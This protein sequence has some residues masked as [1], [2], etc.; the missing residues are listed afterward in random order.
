MARCCSGSPICGA[1]KL[2]TALTSIT[3]VLITFA[4]LC[5]TSSAVY[6]D[7]VTLPTGVNSNHSGIMLRQ[8]G[9]RVMP[10]S[11]CDNL[12]AV[13]GRGPLRARA[14]GTSTRPIRDQID[15]VAPARVP[16]PALRPGPEPGA[17]RAWGRPACQGGHG[18]AVLGLSQGESALSPIADV[19]GKDDFARLEHGEHNII[20]LSTALAEQLGVSK[21]QMVLVGGL[22]CKWP[23]SL[24]LASLTAASIFSA[25]SR[26]RLCATPP[27]RWMPAAQAGRHEG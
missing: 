23:A 6:L 22:R 10:E 4:V 20:Y 24:T 26:F 9:W 17:A 7:T 14:G 3:I 1:G 18:G 13:V 19:I 16:A 12:L 21:G 25:A 5:F 15:L 8:R 27:V 11:V 2:R